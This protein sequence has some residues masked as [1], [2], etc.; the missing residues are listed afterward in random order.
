MKKSL[1]AIATMLALSGC[2]VGHH[3]QLYVNP[4][5]VGV[6]AG[7]AVATMMYEPNVYYPP[8]ENAYVY[9]PVV[10]VYFFVGNDHY[11]HNM[12]RGW[13]YRTHGVPHYQPRH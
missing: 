1:I 13:G 11:R 10:G 7:A 2:A 8:Y 3:G 12:P 4:V 6:I 5:A 9:D